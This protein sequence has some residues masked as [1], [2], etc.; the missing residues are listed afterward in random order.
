M[1]LNTSSLCHIHTSA[2]KG[3]IKCLYCTLMGKAHTMC[4]A[5][6]MPANHWDEFILTACYLSNHT[7]IFSQAGHT[8]YECWY[9][10]K[11]DLTHLRRIGCHT[12]ILIQNHHNPKI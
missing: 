4:S 10:Q 9:D 5:S 6:E 7:L 2:Q 3:R 8:P 12:F 1:I 11:P